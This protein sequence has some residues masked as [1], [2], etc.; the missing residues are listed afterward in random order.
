M[1]RCA[2]MVEAIR[3]FKINTHLAFTNLGPVSLS[4]LL[5]ILFIWWKHAKWSLSFPENLASV[6]SRQFWG[7][8]GRLVDAGY[9]GARAWQVAGK[10]SSFPKAYGRSFPP[11][12]VIKAVS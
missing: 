10:R 1:I 3:E 2:W 4:R 9:L 8:I 12:E 11:L 6:D 5:H 7:I